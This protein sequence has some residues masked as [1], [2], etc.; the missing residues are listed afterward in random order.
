MWIH[1][2]W[3]VRGSCGTTKMVEDHSSTVFSPTRFFRTRWTAT[4]R[5]RCLSYALAGVAHLSSAASSPEYT[6]DG[7]AHRRLD[8]VPGGGAGSS[9][10]ARLPFWLPV[11]VMAVDLRTQAVRTTYVCGVACTC[12]ARTPWRAWFTWVL[13]RVE[14][15]SNGRYV[16]FGDT[17]SV[18]RSFK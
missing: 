9:R 16:L 12:R 8:F 4:C 15:Q 1:I 11:V 7:A 6:G 13:V 3:V 5:I 10:A 2:Q 14:H 18:P 17:H